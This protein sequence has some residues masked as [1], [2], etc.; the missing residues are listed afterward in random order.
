MTPRIMAATRRLLKTNAM[1]FMLFSLWVV[2]LYFS[3]Y[4]GIT[5]ESYYL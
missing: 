5:G 1:R 4:A 2:L 3:N